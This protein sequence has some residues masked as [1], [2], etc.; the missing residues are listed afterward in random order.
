MVYCK[1]LWLKHTAVGGL[2]PGWVDTVSER[3]EAGVGAAEGGA[4]PVLACA[5]GSAPCPATANC[6]VFR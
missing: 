2:V 6:C 1:A 3:V 5:A 4:V